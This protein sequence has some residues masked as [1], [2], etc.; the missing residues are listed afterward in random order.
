MEAHTELRK[1][2]SLLGKLTPKS[3]YL[4]MQLWMTAKQ[5]TPGDQ[6]INGAMVA[7]QTYLDLGKSFELPEDKVLEVT[8]L[9][10]N[11]QKEK[12]AVVLQKQQQAAYALQQEDRNKKAAA[13]F[14]KLEG[15]IEQKLG[16]KRGMSLEQMKA[17]RAGVPMLCHKV[18]SGWY[19]LVNLGSGNEQVRKVRYSEGIIEMTF[20]NNQLKEL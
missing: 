10:M 20:D 2:D 8:R 18:A 17:A 1:V 6:N 5:Q 15:F 7:C 13:E 11:L 9:Y 3:Q 4:R 19:G 16:L 12:E 14:K